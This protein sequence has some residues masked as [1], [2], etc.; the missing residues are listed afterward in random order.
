MELLGR[1]IR[2]AIID[3]DGTLADSTSLWKE[4]DKKFF[5]KRGMDVPS[6]YGEQ[7][8]H[9]GLQQGAEWTVK[10]FLPNERPEDLI[11]EWREASQ[12]A[13]E[14]EIPL[15][16]GAKEALEALK[17]RGVHLSLATANSE[18]LYVPCLKR[19]G[20]YDD[21]EQILD[22]KSIESG[23]KSSKIYDTLAERFHVEKENVV[24]FEDA[25]EA[26]TTAHNAG[27]LSIGVFD[28]ESSLSKIENQKHCDLFLKNWQQFLDLLHE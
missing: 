3:L 15:K 11:L 4:I 23:K 18:E 17:R 26:I 28:P 19:T 5:A 8:V 14:E 16:P 20:I 24:V 9:M 22:V 27:Y 13:Y 2:L 21:F 6:L 1:D 12:K 10:L 25:L 7:I